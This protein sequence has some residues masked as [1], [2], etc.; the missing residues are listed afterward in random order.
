VV[1]HE[2]LFDCYRL[3]PSARRAAIE[4]YLGKVVEPSIPILPYDARAAGWHA[5]ERAR[6]SLEGRTPPFADGQIAAV[7]RVNGLTIVTANLAD[8]AGFQD[9]HVVDWH[10]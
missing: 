8:Y 5:A 6:L 10:A 4:R 7:A 1:W 2:L 9:I 3:P